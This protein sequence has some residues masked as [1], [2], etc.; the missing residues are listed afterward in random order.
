M[1]FIKNTNKINKIL[2]LMLIISSFIF[3]SLLI[4]FNLFNN[5]NLK[6]KPNFLVDLSQSFENLTLKLI[7]PE[8]KLQIKD[9]N[10]KEEIITPFNFVAIGDSESY[11][12]DTRYNDELPFVLSQ[13]KTL[14][15]DFAVFNGDIITA[16]GDNNRALIQNV[17]SLIESNFDRYFLVLDKHDYECGEPCIDLWFDIFWNKKI[18]DGEQRKLYYSFD[19][20]NT[21]FAVL[22]TSYPIK[23]SVD[24]L[25]LDW[26]ANDLQ[27][28]D[29]ENIIVLAHVPMINFYK[30]SKEECHDMSCSEPNRT[31]LV[32]ILENNKVDL[33][34]LGHEATFDH[35]EKNGIDYVIVGNVGNSA[36]Y[37]DVISGDVFTLVEVNQTNITVKALKVRQT[38]DNNLE[39]IKEIR[40]K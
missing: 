29:K 33:V 20:K 2:G 13:A 35:K 9:Y 18:R 34:L 36:K 28:T 31:R 12:T 22:S 37:D 21:H 17:K 38:K 16:T 19:Y 24:D 11:N 40:I 25:Q 10:L 27:K 6:A 4:V 23:Y 5:L 1:L 8:E 39:L 30:E 14:N 26:L 32:S 7:Q 3:L 15:P